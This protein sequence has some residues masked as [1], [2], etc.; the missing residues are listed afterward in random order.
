MDERQQQIRERAGLEESRLNQDFIEFLNK[1]GTNILMCI[2]V[3]ALGYWGYQKYQQRESDKVAAAY[4]ALE[5]A[6]SGDNPSPD[7]LISVADEWQGRGAVSLLARREAADIYLDCVARGIKPGAVVNQDGTLGS[8]DDEIKTSDDRE[9]LL[10]QAEANYQWILDHARADD[11]KAQHTMGA[12]YGLASVAECR[13]Q[14]DKA[15]EYYSQ[16][17]ELTKRKGFANHQAIAQKRLDTLP[18]LAKSEPVPAKIQVPP[19]I[20]QPKPELP[21]LTTTPPPAG[22][23]VIPAPIG[24]QP[25]GGKPADTSPQQ[26][27][28]PPGGG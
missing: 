1:W 16:I 11:D 21:A 17:V 12:L 24:A 6:R 15:K 26:P 3:V 20:E 19:A 10:Q 5:A 27:A 23:T 8:S 4:S 7:T 25:A 13:G 22:A 2:A 18:E 28:T 14:W 9:T